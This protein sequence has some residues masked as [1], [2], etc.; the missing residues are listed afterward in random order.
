MKLR[1]IH[2]GMPKDQM[3][4]GKSVR[5]AIVKQKIQGPVFVSKEGATGDKPAVHPDAVYVCPIESYEHWSAF[6][7][8]TPEYCIDG[9]CG[10]N[11]TTSGLTEEVLHVGDILQFGTQLQTRVVGCRIPCDKFAW[12][13]GESA[14]ILKKVQETGKLGFYLEVLNEGEVTDEDEIQIIKSCPEHI[15]VAELCKFIANPDTTIQEV[16]KVLSTPHLGVAATFFLNNRLAYLEDVAITKKG[17]WKGERSFSLIKI[18]DEAKDIKSFYFKPNDNQLIAGYSAGQ[19]L[20]IQLT[21]RNQEKI[22]RT[23][24][25][26]D[27]DPLGSIYRVTIKR[28]AKG[29]ASNHMHKNA[30]VGDTFLMRNPIGQFKLNKLSHRPIVFISGG[31]GLTPLLSMLKSVVNG[32]TTDSPAPFVFW[33]ECHHNS[34]SHPFNE[35]VSSLLDKLPYAKRF[36]IYTKPMETD[37]CHDSDK[38]FKLDHTKN[39]LSTLKLYF[40]GQ[41]LDFPGQDALYYLCGPETLQD[42]IKQE[43]LEWGVDKTHILYELFHAA[44]GAEEGHT[45]LSSE[46]TFIRSNKTVTWEAYDNQTLLE[47]A[48]ENGIDADYSCRMGV[49]QTCQSRLLEGDVHYEFSPSTPISDESVL[50]C[51]ARPGSSKLIID[52]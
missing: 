8:I 37:A 7:N 48:E 32:N 40:S 1:S 47:L 50:M 23:W 29:Q 10:E 30:K 46:V 44:G 27:Y 49:C 13:M 2:V 39:Q 6:L 18:V 17:R 35:E 3:I 15:S 16:K 26:S 33:I 52:K 22:T 45:V 24:S 9:R 11:F 20:T 42:N 51:I 21:L 12:R 5:T 41:W 43:L 34:Q 31:I 19:F 28:L 38:R 25:I 36:L 4:H 14:S